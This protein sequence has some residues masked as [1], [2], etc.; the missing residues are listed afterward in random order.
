MTGRQAPGLLGGPR[1]PPAG[2]PALAPPAPQPRPALPPLPLWVPSSAG[3][4]PSSHGAKVATCSTKVTTCS[5]CLRPTPTPCSRPHQAVL[6]LDARR[7]R[8]S[9]RPSE[10]RDPERATPPLLPPP[11]LW[12]SESWCR[13]VLEDELPAPGPPRAHTPGRTRERGPPRLAARERDRHRE[14]PRAQTPGRPRTPPTR[15]RGGAHQLVWVPQDHGLD[16]N[17]RDEGACGE[18]T[19][20]D[21][22]APRGRRR[23]PVSSRLLRPC[24]PAAP[25]GVPT[26]VLVENGAPAPPAGSRAGASGLPCVGG[27]NGGTAGS[28]GLPHPLEEKRK[29]GNSIPGLKVIRQVRLVHV[30]SGKIMIW[31]RKERA[32]GA[33]RSPA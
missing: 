8:L 17:T 33:K 7:S 3:T 28:E 10:A 18:R 5:A 30:P 22:V 19:G 13:R 21:D 14:T 20:R 12:N 26:S 24:W 1:A 9:P 23:N 4:L 29:D 16:G 6:Q 27:G 11:A 25:G 2:V 15:T 31:K 32:S